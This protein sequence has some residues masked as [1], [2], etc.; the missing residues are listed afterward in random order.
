[1]EED[2]FGDDDYN[3]K[4][5]ASVRPATNSFRMQLACRHF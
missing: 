5:C 4:E 2:N 1:M 3:N